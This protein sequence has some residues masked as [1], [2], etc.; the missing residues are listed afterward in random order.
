MA[1]SWVLFPWMQGGLRVAS[2]RCGWQ[3]P[4]LFTLFCTVAPV[5][6][7]AAVRPLGWLEH[8]V[9]YHWPPLRV[10]DFAFGMAVAEGLVRT[11]WGEAW[12]LGDRAFGFLADLTALL[13]VLMT[14][15]VHA[16]GDDGSWP[17]GNWDRVGREPI[18]L[19]ILA[20]F[21]GAYFFLSSCGKGG[22]LARVLRHRALSSLGDLG[23]QVYLSHY[24]IMW[25]FLKLEAT[26]VAARSWLYPS[27]T[28]APPVAMGMVGRHV[29]SPNRDAVGSGKFRTQSFLTASIIATYFAAGLVS[30]Y[31]DEPYRKWM[32]TLLDAKLQPPHALSTSPARSPPPPRPPREAPS[33]PAPGQDGAPRAAPEHKEERWWVAGTGPARTF[34]G[35]RDD[36]PG[37]PSTSAEEQLEALS[38]AVLRS[39]SAEMVG[40]GEDDDAELHAS[41]VE[42]REGSLETVTP[43]YQTR[44]SAP[45]PHLP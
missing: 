39:L 45:R 41:L 36:I 33:A 42:S 35:E 14:A 8:D 27:E 11:E 23:F 21:Y 1:F 3:L 16:P 7:F 43:Q 30:T 24:L 28:P 20:P 34:A 12:G 38:L 18:W 40:D 22:C 17:N 25:L 5:C 19:T 10:A 15:V 2:Q 26:D 31:V 6:L 44:G 32:R 4:A 13:F 29:F 9:F 37:G